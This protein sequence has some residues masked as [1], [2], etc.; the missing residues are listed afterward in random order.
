M[1]MHGNKEEDKEREDGDY[2]AVVYKLSCLES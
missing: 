1:T 2:F